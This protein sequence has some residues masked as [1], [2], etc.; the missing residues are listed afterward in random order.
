MLVQTASVLPLIPPSSQLILDVTTAAQVRHSHD[1]D[2]Q[3]RP[4]REVL[5]ALALARLRVVLLPGEARLLPTLEDG[6]DEILAQAR[7]EVS[8]LGLVGT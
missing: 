2:D 3:T 8:G 6:V 1:L 5:R 7:V 4:A